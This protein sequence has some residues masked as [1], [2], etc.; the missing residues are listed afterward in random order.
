MEITHFTYWHCQCVCHCH[1]VF[2]YLLSSWEATLAQVLLQRQKR[3]WEALRQLQGLQRLLQGL[4]Q[5]LQ[6]LQLQ[7]RQEVCRGRRGGELHHRESCRPWGRGLLQEGHLRRQHWRA[8]QHQGAERAGHLQYR[9]RAGQQRLQQGHEVCRGCQ[10]RWV[11]EERGQ[12]R[13]EVHLHRR[14]GRSSG[15]V[16]NFLFLKE[17][18]TNSPDQK[19]VP[20]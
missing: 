5:L 8:G 12:V 18:K 15:I 19:K 7:E 17:L 4:E 20:R 3:L 14:H 9:P 2:E 16:L 11:L 1:C 10:V 6:G 13:A